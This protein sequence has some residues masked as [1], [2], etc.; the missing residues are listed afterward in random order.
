MHVVRTDRQLISQML[1]KLLWFSLV[2]IILQLCAF[3]LGG[4]TDDR[5]TLFSLQTGDSSGVLAGAFDLRNPL[6][7]YGLNVLS[8]FFIHADSA[9]LYTNLVF[10]L[11][12]LIPLEMRS[13]KLFTSLMLGAGHLAG[14]LGAA[15]AFHFLS[16][17]PLVAG[18]SGGL[19]A[20][21]VP[22]LAARRKTFALTFLALLCIGW[23]I[24]SW[25]SFASHALPIAA[26]WLL[27]IRQSKG[28]G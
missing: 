20:A 13:G 8:S 26:G 6:R 10:A 3:L 28:G 2:I 18:M 22:V 16:Q 19:L 21:A 15:V 23:S 4:L 5:S 17:P 14:L 1:K 24:F 12:V 7:N 9:H 25:H 27:S 11:L